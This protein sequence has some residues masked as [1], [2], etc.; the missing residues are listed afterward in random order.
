ME[1]A[2]LGDESK[3]ESIMT[4]SLAESATEDRLATFKVLCMQASA[5][6]HVGERTQGL[7]WLKGGWALGVADGE[8]EKGWCRADTEAE[9]EAAAMAAHASSGD[10]LLQDRRSRLGG[11]CCSLVGVGMD[12]E[13][14]MH[15]PWVHVIATALGKY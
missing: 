10:R 8:V 5:G 15:S 1:A 11:D 7:T 3:L 14:C 12:C 9:G 4:E 6:K 2:G 13:V